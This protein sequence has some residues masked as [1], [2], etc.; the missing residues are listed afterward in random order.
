MDVVVGTAFAAGNGEHSCQPSRFFRDCPDFCQRV[1]ASRFSP[2]CPGFLPVLGVLEHM[3]Y[4]NFPTPL[5]KA[6]IE[7]DLEQT[8]TSHSLAQPDSLPN[9]SLSVW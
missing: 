2:S 9:A 3:G 6:E 8:C 1:P 5:A 4:N 7:V